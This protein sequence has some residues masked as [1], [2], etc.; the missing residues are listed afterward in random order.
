MEQSVHPRILDAV[1]LQQQ[2]QHLQQQQ[3]QEQQELDYYSDSD[4]DNGASMHRLIFATA[5]NVDRQSIHYLAEF[6][7]SDDSHEVSKLEL[8]GFYSST[9]DIPTAAW[10]CLLIFVK[11][12]ENRQSQARVLWIW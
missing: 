11:Q 2:R 9:S 5:Y 6:L 10:M 12:Y 8:D 4:S 7:Q 3:Q 1:R